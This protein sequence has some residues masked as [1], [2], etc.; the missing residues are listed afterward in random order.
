M[1]NVWPRPEERKS[2]SIP[3]AGRGYFGSFVVLAIIASVAFGY[4][5]AT[6]ADPPGVGIGVAIAVLFSFLAGY[7]ALVAA[8]HTR[9]NV[10]ENK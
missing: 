8:K 1:E 7:S 10:R 4:V 5:A 6:L 2:E 3:G 9:R